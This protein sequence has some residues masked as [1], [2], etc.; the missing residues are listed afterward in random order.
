MLVIL[1]MH[2]FK[3]YCWFMMD[4]NYHQQGWFGVL[5]RGHV[6]AWQRHP[7]QVLMMCCASL[8]AVGQ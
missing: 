6:F 4:D 1:F 7:S 3:L 5:E 2:L 8:P